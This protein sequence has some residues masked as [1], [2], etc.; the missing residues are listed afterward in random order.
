MLSYPY[1]VLPDLSP[2]ALKETQRIVTT[3]SAGQSSI[4]A[5]LLLANWQTD[6]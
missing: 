1:Y 3:N 5:Q 4:Q 6:C 2:G